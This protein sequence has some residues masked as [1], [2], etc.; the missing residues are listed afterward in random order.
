MWA[1]LARNGLEPDENDVEGGEGRKEQ[2]QNMRSGSEFTEGF[3]A[4]SQL[5]LDED[6]NEN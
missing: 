5:E 3:R 4:T 2:K 6:H 1:L